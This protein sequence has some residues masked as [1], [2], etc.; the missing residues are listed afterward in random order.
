M[1]HLIDFIKEE[2]ELNIPDWKKVWKKLSEDDKKD[3]KRFLKNLDGS[4]THSL[5][6]IKLF[7]DGP[8]VNYLDDYYERCLNYLP[9]TNREKYINDICY[10]YEI[11]FPCEIKHKPYFIGK[12]IMDILINRDH[13]DWY[14]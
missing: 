8:M 14:E 2:F 12:V 13:K 11:P 9:K 4:W 3:L 5:D 6:I 7:S 1:R 10:L